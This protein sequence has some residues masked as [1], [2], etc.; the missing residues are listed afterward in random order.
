MAQRSDD[1]LDQILDAVTAASRV[2]VGIATR[3]LDRSGVAITLAQCRALV[4]LARSGPM[5]LTELADALGVSPSTATRM[6]DRLLAKSLITREKLDGAVSL[7]ASP[8]GRDVVR[9]VMRARRNELCQVVSQLDDSQ[10]DELL[11]CMDAF[12]KAAG[13]SG[14]SERTL[15]WWD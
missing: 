1:R 14:K 7:S 11:R 13:K 6:C 8:A 5:K 4:V 9:K 10:Q 2:L 15:G 12:R 3:S